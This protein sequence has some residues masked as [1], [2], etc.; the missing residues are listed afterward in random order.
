MSGSVEASKRLPKKNEASEHR[1]AQF[2]IV[3]MGVAPGVHWAFMHDIAETVSQYRQD[4]INYRFAAK[5]SAKKRSAF[6]GGCGTPIIQ[7]T[8]I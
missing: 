5:R 8:V 3:I 6:S 1:G 2:S 4:R 7:T